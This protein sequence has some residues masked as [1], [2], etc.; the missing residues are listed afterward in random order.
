MSGS[1]HRLPFH[2]TRSRNEQR[3]NRVRI[4]VPKVRVSFAQVSCPGLRFEQ[5]KNKDPLLKY[6]VHVHAHVHVDMLY[7]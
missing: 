6:S 4:H 1:E 2:M 3:H 5:N 7:T